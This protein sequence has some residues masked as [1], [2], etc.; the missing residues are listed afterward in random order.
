MMRL[1]TLLA[2]LMLAGTAMA[3]DVGQ[4]APKL[5]GPRLM[6]EQSISLDELKGKVVLVDFWASWCG[7]CKM[8]LP[9]FETLKQE[10][11][12]AGNPDRFEILAVNLDEQ[13]EDAKRFL[14]RYPVSYPII[15]DPEGRLPT[16]YNVPTMPTSFLIDGDGVVRW[17]H[18]GFRNGDTEL[19]R[20]AILKLLEQ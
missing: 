3:V 7:P 15:S 5:D 18:E 13:P 19:F 11:V 17:V 12:A 2:G 1:L 16:R 20:T 6:Y 10:L 14:R 4:L 8:S 9:E